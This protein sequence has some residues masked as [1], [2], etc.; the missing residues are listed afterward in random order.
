MHHGG[1][2]LQ[3]SPVGIQVPVVENQDVVIGIRGVFGRFHDE[4]PIESAIELTKDGNLV[5]V[6]PVGAGLYDGKLVVMLLARL[7]GGGPW[8]L[9][10]SRPCQ[11]TFIGTSSWLVTSITTWAPTRATMG[12]PGTALLYAQT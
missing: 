9:G 6:I 3:P 2:P 12:E 1:H 4:R 5:G 7:D 8:S 11:W 10:T